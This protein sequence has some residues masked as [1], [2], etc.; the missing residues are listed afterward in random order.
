MCVRDYCRV[1]SSGLGVITVYEGGLKI[2][3]TQSSCSLSMI[4]D[5]RCLHGGNRGDRTGVSGEAGEGSRSALEKGEYRISICGSRSGEGGK[6]YSLLDIVDGEASRESGRSGE[7]GGRRDDFRA[8][9][10]IIGVVAEDGHLGKSSREEDI[11]PVLVV[12]RFMGE[13]HLVIIVP[14]ESVRSC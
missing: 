8:V 9:D 2:T 12:W 7:S 13:I 4:G 14:V 10:E 11:H 3:Q 1:V 5:E 6:T